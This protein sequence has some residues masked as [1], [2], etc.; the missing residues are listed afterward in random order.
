M[1]TKILDAVP[2][3]DNSSKAPC[4]M[5]KQVAAQQSYFETVKAGKEVVIAAAC[6]DDVKAKATS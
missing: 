1:S 5:Q 4:R 6:K 2:R 3:V